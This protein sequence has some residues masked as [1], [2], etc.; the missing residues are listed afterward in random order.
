MQSL[1]DQLL[2]L[3]AISKSASY[4]D[5]ITPWA[6]AI[7]QIEFVIDAAETSTTIRLDAGATSN[8]ASKD[9]AGSTSVS[10]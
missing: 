4:T 8:L 1:T 3:N 2:K 10:S 6:A 5:D 9:Q 7:P